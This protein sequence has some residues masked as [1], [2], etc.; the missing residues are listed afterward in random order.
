M[1]NWQEDNNPHNWQHGCCECAKPFE[2]GE[3]FVRADVP[4]GWFRGDDDVY[5]FHKTCFTKEVERNLMDYAP[6]CGKSH[7]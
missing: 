7:D 5:T 4:N 2:K 1:R 6:K 3:S